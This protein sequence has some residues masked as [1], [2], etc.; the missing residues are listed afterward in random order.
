[1]ITEKVMDKMWKSLKNPD[2]WYYESVG[3]YQGHFQRWHSKEYYTDNGKIWFFISDGDWGVHI[4][5]EGRR[6]SR[7]VIPFWTKYNPFNKK[8]RGLRKAVR[9]MKRHLSE[10]KGEN[11]IKSVNKALDG[12]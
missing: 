2:Q 7:F 4:E 5:H 12:I 1:M 10:K 3:T 6:Y 11:Y 9:E 8:M